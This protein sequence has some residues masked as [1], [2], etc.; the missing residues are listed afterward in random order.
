MDAATAERINNLAKNLKD[1][2]L[3]SSMDDAFQK[4]RDIILGG[5]SSGKPLNALVQEEGLMEQAHAVAQEEKKENEQ[6]T[7]VIDALQ[8]IKSAVAEDEGNSVDLTKETV[9]MGEQLKK[10][11][12]ELARIRLEI[13]Q[14]KAA[15]EQAKKIADAAP[16]IPSAQT[17]VQKQ[18]SQLTEEEKKKSDLSSIFNFGNR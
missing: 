18:R 13:E 15:L 4:A 1:L 11:Q 10:E 2:H 9:Q 5:D 7:Q 16:T 6:V 3:A 12:Q 17:N 8:E 14:A